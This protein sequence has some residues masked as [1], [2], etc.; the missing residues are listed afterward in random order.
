[1][2]IVVVTLTG[3][4]QLLLVSRR[5]TWATGAASMAARLASQKLEQLRA[6]AWA[7]DADGRPVADE[8]TDLSTDPSSAGGTGLRS[9]PAGTLQQNLAGF[10]DYLDVNGMWR[11]NGTDPP[12]GAAYVRRWAIRPFTAD[13]AHTL[14]FHVLVAPLADAAGADPARSSRAALQTTIRTRGTQ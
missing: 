13:P 8:Q 12:A 2:A 3:I 6:L 1:M 5:M 11:G 7:F 4:A 14:V 9:S 10:V